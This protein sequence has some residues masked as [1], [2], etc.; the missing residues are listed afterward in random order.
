MLTT[1]TRSQLDLPR[2]QT[3]RVRGQALCTALA[4]I[5]GLQPHRLSMLRRLPQGRLL[6]SGHRPMNW[7]G[8]I[9]SGVVKLMLNDPSGRQQIVGLQFPGD[10]V[11]AS[12]A[13]PSTLIAEAA[14]R[15]EVCCFP[16]N[17][18]DALVR[19]NATVGQAML[20]HTLSE[21]DQARQWM[22]VLGNKSALERVATFLLVLRKRSAACGP[23]VSGADGDACC[24]NTSCA[25]DGK[26]VVPTVPTPE[27]IELP[28]SRSEIAEYLS[29][30][31][32]TVSRQLKQLREMGAVETIGRRRIE[33]RD[34]AAL[35]ALAGAT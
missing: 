19:E 3:C 17:A 27:I 23:C 11:G 10:Y 31:L 21:L 29:L 14:T 28:L 9:V 34:P 30:S 18:F 6:V 13:Q 15:L 22:I 7:F 1:P 32:E 24:A 8:I 12:G 16:R 35:S 26:A 33:I 2:C 4:G 20:Q 25:G 5:P